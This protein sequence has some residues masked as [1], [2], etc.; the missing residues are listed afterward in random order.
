MNINQKASHQLFSRPD[1][2]C[3]RDWT[4]LFEHLNHQEANTQE[5]REVSSLRS[6]PV[7]GS[8]ELMFECPAFNGMAKLNDWTFKQLCGMTG[9]RGVS[10]AI[11]ALSPNTASLALNELLDR[12]EIPKRTLLVD[13]NGLEVTARAIYSGKYER[14]SDYDVFRSM[15]RLSNQYGYEPAGNFC[16]KR[17][18]LSP[19]RPEASGLYA[20]SEDSFGFIANEEGSIDIDNSTLYHMF[21]FGNSEVTKSTFWFSEAYYS[22]ICGNHNIYGITNMR[23]GKKKHIGDVRSVFEDIKKAFQRTDEERNEIR[24]S[25]YK[26]HQVAIRRQFADTLIRTEERLRDYLTHKDARSVLPWIDH[27]NAYP[28]NPLSYFGVAQAVTL[29][30][31][32]KNTVDDR[33][34]M[35]R[36]AGEIVAQAI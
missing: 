27:P 22:F 30:S 18:G 26:T 9:V 17:G 21:M 20:G 1:D 19:V 2:E 24:D 16:G 33:M 7:D 29:A 12:A 6:A 25:V 3:F 34:K 15:Y 5:I 11:N 32:T 36:V 14:V 4:H 13:D 28:K 23:H 31:Q 10:A 8:L 35:D